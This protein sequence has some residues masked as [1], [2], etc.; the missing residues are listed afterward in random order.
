MK[1]IVLIFAVSLLCIGM[2]FGCSAS[3]KDAAMPESSAYYGGYMADAADSYYEYEPE[4]PAAV[5]ES[6]SAWSS[7]GNTAAAP[8]TPALANR[9][10]IRNANVNVQTL[11]FDKFIESLDAAINGVGGFVES[12]NVGGTEYYRRNKLRSAT[13]VIRVPAASLDSFL[14][15]IDG[16]GNVTSMSTNMRDVTTSYVDSEKHLEALRAEQDALLEILKSATTVEDIITVQ[17]RLSYVKY[18]IESYESILRSYDDQ[19]DLS[20]VTLYLSE[21]EHETV[22]EPETFGQEVARKFRESLENVGDF[23]RNLGVFLFG[24]APAILVFLAFNG[25]IV[26]VVVLCIRG[27]IKRRAKR[28]AKKA[29]QQKAE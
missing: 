22:V 12:S 20:T 28:R 6:K 27:G 5:E 11:E 7:N 15:T 25:L 3:S 18:E 19:I 4:A 23:F 24:S 17:D 16:L 10:I 9:K 26:L 29:E 14:N 2:L 21:V 1:R 13:F 8:E